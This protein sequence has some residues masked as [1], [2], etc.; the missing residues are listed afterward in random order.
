MEV[1]NK[2][3]K[4][5]LGEMLLE[6]GSLL[7]TSGANTERIKVTISRIAA[8]FGCDSDLLITN[9]ALMITLTYQHKNKVFTSVKWVPNMH[10][11]FNLISDI[12]IMSWQIV[13][14]KWTV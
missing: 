11:N 9:H 1:I 5:E 2:P 8:A 14:E 7:M 10:L 3:N 12:S 6:I 4:Y 13:L